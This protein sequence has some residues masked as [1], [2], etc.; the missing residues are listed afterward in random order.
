MHYTIK[1]VSEKT[2]LT[3]PTIRYYESEGILPPV[4]RDGSGSRLFGEDDIEWLNLICCLRGTGMP[5]KT[6]KRFVNCCLK[7]DDTID[8]RIAILSEHEKNVDAQL[9]MPQ[10]YKSSLAWKINYHKELKKQIDG[11]K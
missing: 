11:C 10:S 3:I 1:Q 5:I 2:G 7:G 9:K 6:I 8:E 4:E